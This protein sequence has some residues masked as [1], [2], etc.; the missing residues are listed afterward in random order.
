MRPRDT[1]DDPSTPARILAAGQVLC[2]SSPS[3][4]EPSRMSSI[5]AGHRACIQCR[6]LEGAAAGERPSSSALGVLAYS[7]RESWAVRPGEWRSPAMGAHNVANP[8]V[9][10][11]TIVAATIDL[12]MM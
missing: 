2:F 11:R 7:A 6:Q 10:T 4:S 12:G 5:R 8:F 3:P 1:A 9:V